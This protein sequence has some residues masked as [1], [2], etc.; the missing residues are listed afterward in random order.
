MIR[1]T[2]FANKKKSWPSAVT[3][4]PQRLYPYPPQATIF[5]L[6]LFH[7]APSYG[8]SAPSLHLHQGSIVSYKVKQTVLHPLVCFLSVTVF[9]GAPAGFEHTLSRA[10][11]SKEDGGKRVAVGGADRTVTIWDVENGRI[12]YKV[13]N[14]MFSKHC[15]IDTH[16]L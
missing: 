2:I 9:L 14:P 13:R 10:A 6:L 4:I 11:W 15:I 8:T 5:S 3:S 1:Y 7:L 12:L 16:L